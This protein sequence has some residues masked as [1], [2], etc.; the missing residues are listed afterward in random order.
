MGRDCEEGVVTVEQ[1]AR[2][3]AG[4]QKDLCSRLH[5]DLRAREREGRADWRVLGSRAPALPYLRT[6]R[7]ARGCCWEAATA[8]TRGVVPAAH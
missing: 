1:I 6:G 7:P 5:S 2:Q 3:G 4:R 8:P